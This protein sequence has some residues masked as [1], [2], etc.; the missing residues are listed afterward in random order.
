MAK[1]A[2]IIWFRKDLRLAD[3]PAVSAALA[4]G[5]PVVGVYVWSPEEEGGWSPG[6]AARVWLHEALVNLDRSLRQRGTH[7]VLRRGGAADELLDVAKKIGA[8]SIFWTRRYEPWSIQQE[9]E[10]E[11]ALSHAG[12]QTR[13]FQGNLLHEPGQVRTGGGTPYRVFTPYW[14]AVEKLDVAKPEVTDASADRSWGQAWKKAA[15]LPI[16]SLEL[17]PV[18]RWDQGILE[19]WDISERG[20]HAVLSRFL[21][22]KAADYGR[23]RDALAV[24]ESGGEP[25]DGV[26]RL[27]PYLHWGQIGVRRVWHETLRRASRSSTARPGCEAWRRQLVWREFAHHVLFHFPWTMDQP[28]NRSFSSFA[29]RDDDKHL[30]AWRKG[31][32]GYPIVDAGMRQLWTT[33][34]MH[35]RARMIVGS[36]LTKDLRIHWLEGA[37]W[38]W[39][40]LVDA[41]AASNT[42]GWQWVSGCG[43]DAAPYFRVF[44]PAAQEKKFDPEARYV[45]HWVPELRSPGEKGPYPQP[46]VDHAQ[47]RDEALRAWRAIR[48]SS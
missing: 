10:V 41:D 30:R 48:K 18:V 47:A 15:S 4:E 37:R 19:R 23:Q 22:D 2:A 12:L 36:F 40:T 11:K 43:A 8:V 9:A 25:G 24:G 7:L 31:R 38:F 42:F 27:S 33:G 32:T 44:N 35:N 20:A 17:R 26:S 5:G 16:D 28:L 6:A 34:W 21:K 13:S 1:G 45:R 46:I 29:W 3:Q 39:D 14:R